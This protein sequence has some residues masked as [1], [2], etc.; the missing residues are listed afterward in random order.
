[1]TTN[2]IGI[3]G[4]KDSTALL[5]WAVYESGYPSESLSVT[6]CDTGNEHELT[7]AQIRLLS[8]RV[9]PVATLKPPL[10]FYQLAHKKGRFPSPTRRFCTQHLKL[11]PTREHVKKLLLA[12]D[13]VLLHSGVR[14]DESTERAG[15]PER[16]WDDYFDAEVY[17]PLLRWT[18]DDVW[19]I[20]ERY[21]IPRN[22]LYALG[23]K[24]VG[25]LPCIMSR[26]D[27]VRMIAK[28]FPARIDLIREAERS[29]PSRAGIATFFSRKTTPLAQ[30]S[31]ELITKKG[32]RMFVPT[33]D[34]VV[35]WSQ[36][37]RG[38]L[39]YLLDFE[40]ASDD[41]GLCPSSFGACE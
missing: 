2:H 27:E 35:R 19:A 24:R 17:R 14:A 34:D 39:Q 41:I 20:H 33:I 22:P 31:R 15:L 10:D 3:S 36:T 38:G 4:G 7:Y 21:G 12:G 16:Q 23:A 29:V 11:I 5:L 13:D 9:H 18:I 30:R 1:M 6:F 25:C 28:R 8:E 32:E 40:D 26:K 37:A